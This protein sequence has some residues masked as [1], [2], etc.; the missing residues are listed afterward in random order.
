MVSGVAWFGST[1]IARS[2]STV[3]APHRGEL[4]QTERRRSAADV[5]R[6]EPPSP[7][8]VHPQL[9]AQRIEVAGH[10][11]GADSTLLYGQYGQIDRQNGTC[12]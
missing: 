7:G 1:S 6:R 5:E 2:R 10:R 12:R 4:S 8:V 9:L 11:P 3:R